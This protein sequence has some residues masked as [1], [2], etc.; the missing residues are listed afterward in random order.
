MAYGGLKKQMD[1]AA[2]MERNLVSK[3]HIE[4][5][6]G[7][8]QVDARRDCRNCLARPNAQARTRTVKYSFSLFS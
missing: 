3:H 5:G 2:E 7:R 8:E 4:S 6:Y 1:V